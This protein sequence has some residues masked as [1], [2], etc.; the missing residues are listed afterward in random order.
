M[1]VSAGRNGRRSRRRLQAG[2][3]L[4]RDEGYCGPERSTVTQAAAGWDEVGKR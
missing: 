4:V 3:R 1:K 2:M